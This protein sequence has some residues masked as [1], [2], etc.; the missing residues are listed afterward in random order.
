M[1]ILHDAEEPKRILLV[2]SLWKT[3]DRHKTPFLQSCKVETSA[4]PS[5]GSRRC[6]TAAPLT[7]AC[8][9][10]LRKAG[11]SEISAFPLAERRDRGLMKRA[12]SSS[13]CTSRVNL[14]G[15][16]VMD[17]FAAVGLNREDRMSS[18]QAGILI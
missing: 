18:A 11:C 16:I 8:L 6:T 3:Q 2:A 17:E 9:I 10:G 1:D 13:R 14:I 4:S 7:P 5:L 12:V 15:E